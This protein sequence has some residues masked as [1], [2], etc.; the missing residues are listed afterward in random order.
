MFVVSGIAA[1]I[2]DFAFLVALPRR[3]SRLP[4][5]AAAGI[6]HLL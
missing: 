4:L 5:A 3:L 6:L 1:G 2:A